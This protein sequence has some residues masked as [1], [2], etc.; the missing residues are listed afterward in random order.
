[1]SIHSADEDQ[2]VGAWMQAQTTSSYPWIGLSTQTCSQGCSGNWAA[3]YAWSDGTATDYRNPSWSQNDNAPTYGHYY[4]NGAWGTNCPSCKA[5]GVC[6][7]MAEQ[8]KDI[9]SNSIIAEPSAK[10]AVTHGAGSLIVGTLGVALVAALTL[11]P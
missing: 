2:L 11:T 9:N 3:E 10:A 1:M 8:N 4:R 6:Q 7:K 5:E